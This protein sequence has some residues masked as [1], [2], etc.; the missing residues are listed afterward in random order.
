M[1]KIMAVAMRM[2][3]MKI[4]CEVP[5]KDKTLTELDVS[6]KNLGTDGALVVAG[7]LDDNRAISSVKLLKNKID[8][9][10]AEDLVRVLKEHPTLK[11]LC[12]NKGD[13]T[14]LDMSGKM[15][16]AGDT[17]MLAAEIVGNG[18]MTSLNVKDN[19]LDDKGKAI[20][21]KANNLQYLICDEWAITPDTTSLD[22]SKKD[23][24]ESDLL[25]LAAILGTI[26]AHC[27]L[28]ILM[29][30]TL[31]TMSC[32]MAGHTTLVWESD[33]VTTLMATTRNSHQLGRSRL[34]SWHWR[35]HS[36]TT[37]PSQSYTL[38]TTILRKRG[39]MHLRM[40]C[41]QTHQHH[42]LISPVTNGHLCQ[43]L[44]AQ[45]IKATKAWNLEMR[46]CLQ[47]CY[48]TTT[49]RWNP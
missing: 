40:L 14:E 43:T 30:T 17:I 12:G 33:F 47:H 2:D 8:V 25:L 16:G 22:L 37:P 20:L 27:C 13:E 21:S 35:E 15:S 24:K 41:Y 29:A 34:A 18:A 4:L 6:G 19:S 10:K 32:Q 9:D 45:S 48:R 42:L 3:N 28:S 5:F 38:R 44:V 49:R 46:C 26:T 39:S 31:V 23:L 1:R 36:T 11:S 7:Y